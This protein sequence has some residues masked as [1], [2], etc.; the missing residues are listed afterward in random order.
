MSA[1]NLDELWIGERVRL[2]KNGQSGR[3]EGSTAEGL[4][5]I[6]VDGHIVVTEAHNLELEKEDND[7][8][9]IDSWLNQP[10]IPKAKPEPI[11]LFTKEIDLHFDETASRAITSDQVLDWQLRKCRK[12]IETAINKKVSNIIIIHG[13]GEGVLRNLVHQMLDS[14]AEVQWKMLINQGGATEVVFYYR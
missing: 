8:N 13:K 11:K 7:D 3:F 12:H 1:L 4:A 10:H 2:I 9:P 14:Y 6:S 5:R